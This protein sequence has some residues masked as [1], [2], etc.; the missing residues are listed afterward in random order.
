MI[1]SGGKSHENLQ[2]PADISYFIVVLSSILIYFIF[3]WWNIRH[4]VNDSSAIWGNNARFYIISVFIYA[5]VFLA[6]CRIAASLQ[7]KISSLKWS[8][9]KV[10]S[11]YQKVIMAVIIILAVFLAIHRVL[12]VEPNEFGI[13][14]T[15][16]HHLFPEKFL[17]L[18]FAVTTAV[19]C[20]VWKDNLDSSRYIL[21]L[22]YAIA[23]YISFFSIY[24]PN[25]LAGDTFHGTAYTE[26]IFN[27]Y[28]LI[29]FD[30]STTG[31]Y[32][33]YGLF[34]APFLALFGGTATGLASLISIVGV[35]ATGAVIYIVHNLTE[36]NVVRIITVFASL[37]PTAVLRI[38]NYWQVQPHRIVWPLLIAAYTIQILKRKKPV[39]KVY[40]GYILCALS[41]V[42]NTEG[43]IFC[44]IAYTFALFVQDISQ[45]EIIIPKL[46]AK[47]IQ[48]IVLSLLSVV[49]AV[50]IV[51]VYNILVDGQVIWEDFFF[52][53]FDKGYIVSTLTHNMSWCNSGWIY[54]LGFG[55]IATTLCLR[56]T[57]LF[58]RDGCVNS[59]D[60]FV[61][62]LGV[63]V[64]T[65]FVYY[66]NRAAY[67]NLDICYQLVCIIFCALWTRYVDEWRHI[68][69]EKMSIK[70]FALGIM[71]G[72][73]SATLI[74]LSL[75]LVFTL[76]NFN[77]K[78]N[79]WDKGM[80]IDSATMIEMEVPKD[81]FAFG[82]TI[83]ALY[84]ELG[85]DTQLHIRDIPDMPLDGGLLNEKVK[86]L[87]LEH[88]A[89]FLCTA[90]MSQVAI[91]VRDMILAQ[92]TRYQLVKSFEMQGFT[93]ELYQR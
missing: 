57:I 76:T 14:G 56:H 3:L 13:V 44:T 41:I 89:F 16:P 51:N 73:C 54:V 92:D 45:E 35:L 46:F 19:L 91:T 40:I 61:G 72:I 60:P 20:Y 80:F 25:I 63:S 71:S 36:K 69:K 39:Y 47:S 87:A 17:I 43:G 78:L 24:F 38:T 77:S 29:P 75:Q 33:H 64:L 22:C 49:A 2:D 55:C 23:L 93:Y 28:H 10:N 31:V 79:A 52:P 81:T 74:C 9:P 83:T 53:I 32:G 34:Y 59:T 26:T 67:H 4:H 21:Y 6:L 1:I 68:L 65:N 82:T 30:R 37:L 12:V 86:Q 90:D 15:L 18:F 42:W 11:N 88:D 8:C 84:Q 70:R 50:M 27:V 5:V 48:Y 66:A 62:Y 85:W 58:K 7:P